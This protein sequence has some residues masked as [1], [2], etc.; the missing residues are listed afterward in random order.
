LRGY[1]VAVISLRQAISQ[2]QQ[3]NDLRLAT[4]KRALLE[5]AAVSED[6][7]D[8][9][10]ALLHLKRHK[11]DLAHHLINTASLVLI[12]AKD[13]GVSRKE[14]LELVMQAALHDVG[15][16]LCP[17]SSREADMVLEERRRAQETIG[18]VARTVAEFER[19]AMRVAVANEIRM[20]VDTKKPV[21]EGYPFKLTAPSKIIAVAHAYDLLTTP[22]RH[23]PALLPDEAL[24]LIYAEAGSRY[25]EGAARVLINVLGVYPVGSLVR[26]SNGQTAIVVEAPVDGDPTKPRV[27]VIKD[28]QGKAI[29]GAFLDLRKAQGTKILKCIDAEENKVNIPAFLLG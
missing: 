16:C 8:M 2:L 15:K 19:T 23:R 27:K 14:I 3:T 18:Q 17:E 12:M 11:V 10:V 9:L 21:N 7:R 28:M 4:L 13:L 26:L 24:Q 1:S 6:C 22:T 29:D 5:L 25:D 20:W